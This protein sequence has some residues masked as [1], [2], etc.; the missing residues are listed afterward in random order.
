M[1][2]SSTREEPKSHKEAVQSRF[3]DVNSRAQTRHRRVV[4]R[5]HLKEFSA[6]KAFP[7]SPMFGPPP[8]GGCPAD[9]RPVAQLAHRSPRL[10]SA[11]PVEGGGIEYVAFIAG[12]IEHRWRVYFPSSDAIKDPMGSI[13][14][15][16]QGRAVPLI[17]RR[18]AR[19]SRKEHCSA[20]S[21]MYITPSCALIL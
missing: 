17:G 15:G 7:R 1:T 6:N 14:A 9:P 8:N 21:V 5:Y 20:H 12:D 3:A 13:S 19:N 18:P 16:R 2:Q 11:V 10:D 4:V